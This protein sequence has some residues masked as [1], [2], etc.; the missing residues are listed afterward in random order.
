MGQSTEGIS[1]FWAP[2]LSA[3]LASDDVFV[4]DLAGIR[5]LSPMDTL[6]S[7]GSCLACLKKPKFQ[8]AGFLSGNNVLLVSVCLS[9]CPCSPP[10]CRGAD[11]LTREHHRPCLCH[12]SGM[13]S[14]HQQQPP[15]VILTHSPNHSFNLRGSVE[16]K[17]GKSKLVFQDAFLKV[18]QKFLVEAKT[19]F[20]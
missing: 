1:W 6:T 19:K 8:R 9:V 2:L 15:G 18:T 14:G 13:S 20:C 17:Q 10:E 7:A 3:S 5:V 11:L 4:T 12:G 16:V